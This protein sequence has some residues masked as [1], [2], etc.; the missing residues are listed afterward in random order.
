VLILNLTASPSAGSLAR[1]IG[2]NSETAW[3]I[4][5]KLRHQFSLICAQGKKFLLGKQVYVEN[6]RFRNVLSSKGRKTSSTHVVVI[7]VKNNAF[8]FAIPRRHPF[9]YRQLLNDLGVKRD[10]FTYDF[11]FNRIGKKLDG[12]KVHLMERK[13]Q[14]N[15]KDAWACFRTGR[16]LDVYLTRSFRKRPVKVNRKYMQDYLSEFVFRFNFAQDK[17][18]MFP[19]LIT[20]LER[21]TYCDEAEARAKIERFDHRISRRLSG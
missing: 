15:S 19:L 4:L 11:D 18:M 1:H 16:A 9:Y 6:L 2:V 3:R 7:A 8:A 20:N 17:A 5:G 21:V 10:I 12:F 13:E 14:D